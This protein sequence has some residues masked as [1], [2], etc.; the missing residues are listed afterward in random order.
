MCLIRLTSHFL[1]DKLKKNLVSCFVIKAIFY[2]TNQYMDDE[3]SHVVCTSAQNAFITTSIQIPR[4]QV[5]DT[6]Y[7]NTVCLKLQLLKD[8]D[9][10]RCLPRVMLLES[11]RLLRDP[12]AV[13]KVDYDCWRCQTVR[14]CSY[15]HRWAHT[16]GNMHTTCTHDAHTNFEK[17]LIM[18]NF[19]SFLLRYKL[20]V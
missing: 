8:R 18:V 10:C 15:T 12:A 5:K 2:Y 20:K 19:M 6:T 9:I 17:M 14:P 3:I 13:N 7:G 16:Y 1:R 11:S 4:P